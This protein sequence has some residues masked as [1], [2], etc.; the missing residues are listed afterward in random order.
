MLNTKDHKYVGA[1]NP[2]VWADDSI[3]EA[4]STWRNQ[5]DPD[6]NLYD[7]IYDLASKEAQKVIA[8]NG[9]Y[10]DREFDD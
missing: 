4:S 8:K 2:G 1:T 9:R 3:T 10:L 5:P 6:A 7:Q